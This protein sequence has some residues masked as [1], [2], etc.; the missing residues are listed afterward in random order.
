MNGTRK[1]SKQW[2]EYSSDK[3]V[4]SM[5]FQQN[6]INPC[7]YKQFSD[8]L[9]LE[10]HGGDFLVCGSS[11]DLEC[12]AD[13]FEEQFLVKKA[14]IV[15]LRPEH[16]KETHFLQ[17]QICVDDFGWHVELDQR[18]VESLLD[19]MGMHHC[20]SMATP[21]SRTRNDRPAGTSTV[22]VRCWDLSVCDR[23]TLRHCLQYEGSHEKGS[24]TNHSLTDKVEADRVLPQ[25][26]PAMCD[27]L[28]LGYQVGGR[29]RCDSGFGLG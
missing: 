6:D 25:R 7:I 13:E 22:L 9:D 17:R 5:L 16:Q 29:H 21:G 3:L 11:S 4:K 12:L 8:N 24:G 1:A 27:E 2:Q 10:Q 26:T 28:P 14:E 15:S 20:K 18:Y 19:A 23:A